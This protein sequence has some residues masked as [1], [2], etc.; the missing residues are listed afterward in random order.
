MKLQ[1]I[2][3]STREGRKTEQLA[4]WVEHEA[5]K[6]S[7]LDVELIDLADYPMPFFDEAI[8]PRYNPERSINLHAKK[9][10]DNLALGDAYIFVSP[11]YNHSTSG[12]LKNAIDYVDFQFNKKPATVV[13]HGTVGGARAIMHLREILSESKLI[14]IPTTLAFTARVGE[15]IDTKGILDA[16]IAAEPYGPQFVLHSLLD[17]ITWYGQVL[18]DARQKDAKA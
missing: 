6:R 5:K 10:L 11:E 2:L 7:Q 14:V 1:I 17:E 16:T 3:G 13:S 15:V 9:F 12:I 8:S 4:K 18:H